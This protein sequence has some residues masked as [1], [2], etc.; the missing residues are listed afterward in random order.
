MNLP[1]LEELISIGRGRENI[2]WPDLHKKELFQSSKERIYD[3]R[4]LLP[5]HRCKTTKLE[6]VSRNE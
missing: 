2:D 3:M 4:N 5:H 1:V 6:H